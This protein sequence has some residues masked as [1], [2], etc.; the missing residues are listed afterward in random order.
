ML[1][2][3][4][5]PHSLYQPAGGV[6]CRA[7]HV[8]Q[9]R[10]IT[11]SLSLKLESGSVITSS[12]SSKAERTRPAVA[13][14]RLSRERSSD[15]TSI[16]ICARKRD[17]AIYKV[18]HTGFQDAAAE[19]DHDHARYPH[20]AEAHKTAFFNQHNI[21]CDIKPRLTKEQHDVLEGHF[22]RA[23]KPNTQ[24]KKGF[25]DTLGVSLDKVNVSCASSK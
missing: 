16:S 12:A 21:S 17:M 20:T 7:R 10:L 2:D 4:Y 15:K 9:I 11:E 3:S 19:D 23:P 24:I 6:F 14:L 1:T 8:T 5:D 13:T 22:Q 18:G 25:A